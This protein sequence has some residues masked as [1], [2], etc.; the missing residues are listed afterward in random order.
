MLSSSFP[1][2][3]PNSLVLGKLE[4]DSD[5]NPRLISMQSN[6]GENEEAR[7]GAGRQVTGRAR[8]SLLVML[9]KLELRDD[10]RPLSS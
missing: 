2:P 1:L 5:I 4:V 9:H 3:E 8:D 7:R 10:T 6:E